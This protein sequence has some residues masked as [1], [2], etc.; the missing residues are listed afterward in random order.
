MKC[1]G[2]SFYSP[3]RQICCNM[4]VQRTKYGKYT[5]CCGHR[6]YHR[7][8]QGCCRNRI[9]TLHKCECC[10]PRMRIVPRG[11]YNAHRCGLTP[12]NIATQ[13]CCTNGI[14]KSVHPKLY[15]YNT[16]CCGDRIYNKKT[17]CCGPAHT[18]RPN[19]RCKPRYCGYTRYDPFTKICCIS[20]ESKKQVHRRRYGLA[21]SCC[22]HRITYNIKTHRCCH[23]G[24]R[25]L[26]RRH[27]CVIHKCG[28]RQFNPVKQICCGGKVIHHRKQSTACCG[29][30]L[31]H[32]HTQRCCRPQL[33][34][35][36]K[37]TPC[38]RLCGL[39]LFHP[40]THI[41]CTK[42]VRGKRYG[43]RTACCADRVYNKAT[44]K[45]CNNRAII[46]KSLSCSPC[47]T[48]YYDPTRFLCCGGTALRP[49]LAGPRTLCCGTSIYNTRTQ[50][51]CRPDFVVALPITCNQLKC[52]NSPFNPT[53]QMCCFNRILHARSFG[54][55]TKCC[56]GN[57]YNQVRF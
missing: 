3:T 23:N 43:D 27:S 33:I 25:V 36:H 6:T 28:G 18:L 45:C 11:T 42:T 10:K 41:C 16:V 30:K 57:I 12:F 51:C 37:N 44:H 1:C 47:L 9:Y 8:R 19:G 53:K 48:T 54:L 13:I 5:K 4:K 38:K 50:R 34:I 49:R 29:V 40:T 2:S 46:L 15:G 17:K 24:Q 31:Y 35:R 7:H 32:V 14:R 20:T 22:G 52:G 21:T 55:N 56:G 39:Q 26:P